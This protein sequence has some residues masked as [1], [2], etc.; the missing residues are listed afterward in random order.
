MAGE[1]DGGAP[2]PGGDSGAGGGDAGG[3]SGSDFSSQYDKGSMEDTIARSLHS[4]REREEAGDDGDDG[5]GE[6]VDQTTGKTIKVREHVRQVKGGNGAAAPAAAKPGAAAAPGQQPA[7]Q[8][9]AEDITKLPTSWEPKFAEKFAA[10]DPELK[11]QIHKREADA[12]NG[13]AQYRQ[14]AQFAARMAEDFVQPFVEDFRAVQ[15]DGAEVIKSVMGTWQ[16]LV[17]GGPADRVG[18]VRQIMSDFGIN[19][20]DLGMPQNSGG[21][22]QGQGHSPEL[23]SLRQEVSQLRGQ[24]QTQEQQRQQASANQWRNEFNRFRSDPKNEFVMQVAPI[25]QRLI[26]GGEAE[27]YEEAYDKA[28]KLEPNVRAT[29]D[30]REAESR[31]KREA[32]EAAAAANANRVN[33]N[34][35]GQRT[36]KTEPLTMD[37]TILATLR[38]IKARG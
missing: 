21:S 26:L 17:R 8:P 31:R 28:C 33:V 24:L 13:V 14:G 5:E 30:G 9:G 38:K 35:R 34:T 36:E 4:I 23:L 2:A 19:P 18:I 22:G 7:A 6:Q 1:V 32:E 20:S 37:D 27:T 15:M 29:M 16:G 3:S 25:M 11:A 12:R 10:L